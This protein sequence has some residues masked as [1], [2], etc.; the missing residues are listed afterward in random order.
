MLKI[1]AFKIGEE[2]YG[3]DIDH[4]Q[5]IER[6]NYITRVPNAPENVKGVINLRGNVTPIIELKSMLNLGNTQYTDSTRVIIT[7]YEDT[8]LGFI[9][10]QTS[11]VMDVSPEYIEAASTSGFDSAFFEGIIKMDGRLIILLKLIELMK[12]MSN[13]PKELGFAKFI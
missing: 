2:E 12:G 4:V 6:I 1:V 10:D 11:D 3:L 8:K 7:T 5:S 13:E 9:V